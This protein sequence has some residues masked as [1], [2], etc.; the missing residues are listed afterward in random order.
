MK[1]YKI[2]ASYLTFCTL[3]IE[4]ENENQAWL[5][6][7]AADGG[8]FHNEGETGDWKIEQVEEITK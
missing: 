4:A 8:D 1:T 7:L 3:E 5:S 6:A 2:T